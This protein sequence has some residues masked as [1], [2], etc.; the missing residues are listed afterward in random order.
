MKEILISRARYAYASVGLV[1]LLVCATVVLCMS[2]V[3]LIKASRISGALQSAQRM[4]SLAEGTLPM[5]RIAQTYTSKTSLSQAKRPTYR[6]RSRTHYYHSSGSSSSGPLSTLAWVLV[7]C[8]LVI[9]IIIGVWRRYAESDDNGDSFE[10]DY[11][12][13]NNRTIDSKS[14]RD[15]TGARRIWA[16]D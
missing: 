8:V 13:S 6:Y 7:I 5:M 12:Y 9:C 10:S 11:Y 14:S 1:C 15:K 4:S 16:N 3:S 2:S